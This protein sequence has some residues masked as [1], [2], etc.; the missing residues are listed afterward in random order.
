MNQKTITPMFPELCLITPEMA[1]AWLDSNSEN[2]NL[3]LGHVDHL[4]R[5]MLQGQ[6]FLTHQ[7]MAFTGDKVAPGRLIDGQHRL[8][9]IAQTGYSVWQWVFWNVPEDSFSAIDGGISRT[10]IDRWGQEGWNKR[11]L[12]LCSAASVIALY[13]GR[14]KITKCDAD[15]IWETFEAPFGKLME[16]CPTTRKSVT[17]AYVQ[18]AV[19]ISLLRFPSKEEEILRYW[20]HLVLEELNELPPSIVRLFVKLTTGLRVGSGTETAMQQLCLALKCFEPECWKL[21][22]IHSDPDDILPSLSPWLAA[23]IW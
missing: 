21:T 19:C 15:K 8:F 11:K 14:R 23:V 2:R 4:G 3:K 16:S 22:R 10:F 1:V 6:F 18:L 7:G 20:R 5:Q 13:P 12:A 17:G 9:A